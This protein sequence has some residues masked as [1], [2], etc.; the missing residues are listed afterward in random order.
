MKSMFK[1]LGIIA[2]VAVMTFAMTACSNG[3]GGSP[4][5]GNSGFQLAAEYF[6][7]DEYG[8]EYKLEIGEGSVTSRAANTPQKGHSYKLTITDK[9]GKNMESTGTVD[10][11]KSLEID[12]KHKSLAKIKVGLK[13]QNGNYFMNSFDGEIPLDSGD[14][15]PSGDMGSYRLTGDGKGYILCFG[16]V[17]EEDGSAYIPASFRGLPVTS[18]GLEYT[19][20]YDVFFEQRTNLKSVEI[21]TSVTTIGYMT[22]RNCTNLSSIIIPSSVTT[23][24]AFDGVGGNPFYGCTSLSTITVDSGNPNYSSEG[25]ILYNKNK[26]KLISWSSASG[27]VTIPSNVTTIEWGAFVGS[28]FNDITIPENVTFIDS[29]AFIGLISSQTIN[30]QGH[31]NQA[32]ADAMWGSGWREGCNAIIKYWNGSSYQ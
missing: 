31:A 9:N 18:I 23:L 21:P 10:D 13:E 1:L 6:A 32:S 22:F 8:T 24:G 11:V 15:I 28:S 2:L 19:L 7:Y 20:Y 26:T 12:L 5:G 3:G 4:K 16:V 30:I 25:G 27:N 29:G 14:T 17:R